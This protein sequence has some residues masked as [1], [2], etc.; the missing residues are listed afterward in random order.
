[1]YLKYRTFLSDMDILR[2]PLLTKKHPNSDF[3]IADI[4]DQTPFK[5]DLASME[6]P[7][8]SLSTKPDLRTIEYQ[9]A[10]ISITVNP[11]FQ[12]GLPTIFDKDL[13]LYCAS[14][15][16]TEVN[17]GRVPPKKIHISPHDFFISTNRMTNGQSY[18]LLQ[19]SLD[20]L[21]GCHIKTNVKTNDIEIKEG[22]SVISYKYFD[23]VKVKD[24]AVRLEI[25]PSDW[26]YNSI[27][28]RQML[29]INRDY[30]RLRKPMERRLY[31]IARKHCGD[32][33][34]W[35]ISL[36]KL[37]LKSGSSGTSRLF[38]SRLKKIISDDNIPDYQ[39]A[40]DNNH[41]VTIT[42]TKFIEED[43]PQREEH[44]SYDM[45]YNLT[46]R[47]KPETI[48]KAEKL[49]AASYTDWSMHEIKVQFLLFMDKKGETVKSLDGAFLNFLKQKVK[50]YKK[51]T[52]QT[53][54]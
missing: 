34:Q 20:R 3:F 43:T 37:F 7:V 6:H 42:R 28:A 8:F 38:K 4:F 52:T 24:R 9:N 33:K 14:L 40:L 23:D 36:D 45:A 35:Y 44:T 17:E 1:M 54:F 31:E 21:S 48:V 10:G 26:F 11:H 51:D 16:M 39:Y 15:L 18:D 30:F 19:K 22:F 5:D 50:T 27:V 41:M 53:I 46:Q 13:L 47:L 12:L 25:T 2:M 32:K 49:H 29:T